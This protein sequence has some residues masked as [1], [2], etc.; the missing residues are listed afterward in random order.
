MRLSP[1]AS[2]HLLART[3]TSRPPEEGKTPASRSWFMRAC[4]KLGSALGWGSVLALALIFVLMVNLPFYSAHSAFRAINEI[5]QASFS[6]LATRMATP[7]DPLARV[8]EFSG[9]VSRGRIKELSAQ[10]TTQ[11]KGMSYAKVVD[12]PTH[13]EAVFGNLFSGIRLVVDAPEPFRSRTINILASQGFKVE[14]HGRCPDCAALVWRKTG[15][16]DLTASGTMEERKRLRGQLSVLLGLGLAT[17]QAPGYPTVV[18]IPDRTFSQGLRQILTGS[19]LGAVYFGLLIFGWGLVMSA[20]L[21]GWTLD[22]QRSKGALEPFIA[23]HHAPWVLYG[24]GILRQA[25]VGFCLFGC[26]LL[27][28]L[29][30]RLPVQWG[31]VLP[32]WVCIPPGIALIGFWSVLATFWF[33]HKDGRMLARL[34]F[35]PI[36]LFVGWTV[37]IAVLWGVL[38]AQN[39]ILAYH[40]FQVA[41]ESGEWLLG[42]AFLLAL[43]SVV[44]AWLVAWRIGPRREGLRRTVA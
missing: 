8:V 7:G 12:D 37:R 26:A 27:L 36:T 19:A 25:V 41:L 33:H 21:H 10:A 11:M 34:L 13:V 18:V 16:W 28:C 42:L 39:P 44:L 35:S 5:G 15:G 24:S 38:Q 32:L 22:Y 20:G 40:R 9:S 1:L 4:L 3:P 17:H 31:F 2:M 23:T 6:Q 29:L 43:G 30:W 14:L